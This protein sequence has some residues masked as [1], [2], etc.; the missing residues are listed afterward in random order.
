[1][2]RVINND[3]LSVPMIQQVFGMISLFLDHKLTIKDKSLIL[4]CIRRFDHHTLL[5]FLRGNNYA[6]VLR[7]LMHNF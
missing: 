1:M 2:Q 4:L 7:V 3:I 5:M 6:Y